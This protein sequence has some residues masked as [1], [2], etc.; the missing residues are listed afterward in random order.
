[1]KTAG[2]DESIWKFTGTAK[3]YESQ[4]DAVEAILGG[5]V[6]AGDVVVIRYEGPKGGPGMQE[7]L[8]PTSYLKSRGLGKQCALLT[9][10]RF[11]GGTSGLSI[12]HV[13]PEAAEGG[14]IG[15]VNNGDRIEIDIPQRSIK[16]LVSN[17]EMASRRAAMEAKG[18]QA[19]QPANRQ[20]VV[21]KALQAYALFAT[22]AATGAVRDL[23]LVK[24]VDKQG[25]A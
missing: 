19:W 3:V 2:V 5:T 13:S 22:S 9:D 23:T 25:R 1:V 15:L 17:A 6:V 8:Y 12:G 7:M 20:R 11:S 14:E 18:D 21:S 24:R 16:L 4:D 10:G